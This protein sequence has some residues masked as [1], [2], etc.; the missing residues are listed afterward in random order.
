MLANGLFQNIFHYN[1]RVKF[2]WAPRHLV[3]LT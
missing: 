3:V 1:N 2:M